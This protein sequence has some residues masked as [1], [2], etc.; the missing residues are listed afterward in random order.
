PAV[1]D[2]AELV[3]DDEPAGARSEVER[4]EDPRLADELRLPVAEV[5]VGVQRDRPGEVQAPVDQVEELRALVGAL[6]AG[7]LDEPADRRGRLEDDPGV[8]LASPPPLV[9][10]A[11]RPV[12]ERAPLGPV[13]SCLRPWEGARCGRG[14]CEQE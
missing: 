13:C 4:A 14:Q 6:D 12:E 5:T 8:R 11:R 1:P 2:A 10:A 7:D 3:E 9:L